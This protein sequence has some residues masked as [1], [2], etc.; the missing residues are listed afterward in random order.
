[1]YI[2]NGCQ[3]EHKFCIPDVFQGLIKAGYYSNVIWVF[4]GGS[5]L[6]VFR[7]QGAVMLNNVAVD[8]GFPCGKRVVNDNVKF[9]TSQTPIVVLVLSNDF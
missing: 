6:P 7:D 9:H 4:F 2:V 8:P 1:M 3:R 5:G